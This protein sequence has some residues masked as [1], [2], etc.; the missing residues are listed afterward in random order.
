MFQYAFAIAAARMLDTWFL[1]D[2]RD[3]SRYFAVPRAPI[4][5]AAMKRLVRASGRLLA[6]REVVADERDEPEEVMAS[7]TDRT[8]Y[9][10]HF[11]SE[12]FFRAAANEVRSRFQ[13]RNEIR[14]RFMNRYAMLVKTGYVAA[15]VRLGDYFEY[16]DDVTLRPGYYRRAFEVL[17]SDL[18]IVVVS[19]EPER[20]RAAFAN[21][22]GVRVEA[23]DEITDFLLLSHASHLISSN[24]SFAW[25]AAWLN[26]N[27]DLRVIA[28]RW[29]LGMHE[30]REVPVRVMREGWQQLD[31]RRRDDGSWSPS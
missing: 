6:R 27:E 22:P 29:W 13:V 23:N 25:W 30:Q 20:V 1:Y 14:N 4:P 7:L 5:N 8:A 3:L 24:S 10:G 21:D 18:P 11:Y 16:R 28:P 19:D 15:H 12:V 17:D 26:E 9:G 31:P 2:T